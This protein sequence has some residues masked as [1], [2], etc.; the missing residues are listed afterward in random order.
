MVIAIALLVI[1]LGYVQLG[2]EG[3]SEQSEITVTNPEQDVLTALQQMVDTV[4]PTE[5]QPESTAATTREQLDF[6][7]LERM[8]AEHGI[9]YTVEYNDSA[10]T[11]V[12]EQNPDQYQ[13][14]DG[15]ILKE[16]GTEFV[17]IAVDIRVVT[18]DTSL[19]KTTV[20]K[21]RPYQKR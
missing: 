20:I 19:T 13:I 12:V 5:I 8:H 6:A 11:T 10:A 7:S 2:Y 3:S 21:Q 18:E 14:V 9:V 17:G 4:E 15:V 16:D 1:A